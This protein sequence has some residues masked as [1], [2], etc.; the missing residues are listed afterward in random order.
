[1]TVKKLASLLHLWLGLAAGLVVILSFLPATIFVWET[2]LT[3]LFYRKYVFVEP[4]GRQPLPLTKLLE[5]AQKS[6]PADQP[7]EDIKISSEPNRA[8]IFSGLEHAEDEGWN[9]FSEMEYSNTVYV[10]QYTGKVLGVVDEETNWISLMRVMHQQLLL[11]YDVGHIIVGIAS[12]MMFVL[13]LTG[14]ILWWPRNKG[15]LKQ[16]FKI[17][18]NAKWRRVNYDFHNV[19]GFYTQLFI[20]IFA[21]TG[22][23][24]TFEWW[25]DGIYRL[26]G[27]DPAKVFSQIPALK[28]DAQKAAHPLDLA[29]SDMLTKKTDWNKITFHLAEKKFVGVVRYDGDSGWD[30]W[31]IHHFDARDGDLYFSIKHEDKSTGAKWRNSNRSIHIGSIYGT[32]TKIIAT[33]VALFGASLPVTGF[34]IWWGRRK[35]EKR[36][37][38]VRTRKTTQA[39]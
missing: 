22:L 19:G 2:E 21:A 26:L 27:E 7:L 5:I 14:L 34:Y 12:L 17:K 39:F 38:P 35:K 1:M 36:L 16:R 25:T 30:T 15:A 29:F 28:P 11:R 20:L 8:Y 9:A 23:V 24:W 32:P 33:I 4:A 31:D 6:V 18:F 10:D 37:K 13:V 3:D